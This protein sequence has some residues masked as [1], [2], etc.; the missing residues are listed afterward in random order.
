M[1]IVNAEPRSGD[2]INQRARE[3]HAASAASK[4][5]ITAALRRTSKVLDRALP[6]HLSQPCQAG[7]FLAETEITMRLQALLATTALAFLAT[8]V[9]L[10]QDQ[11]QGGGWGSPQ[12]GQDDFGMGG[13]QG[14]QVLTCYPQ[15]G[16]GPSGAMTMV[17]Y[18]TASGQSGAQSDSDMPFRNEMG[19]PSGS[20][21][22]VRT[23]SVKRPN[24]R[25]SDDKG[26]SN[27]GQQ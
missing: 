18:R 13:G 3:N 25:G 6:S 22:A 2:K 5:V 9:A 7:G 1:T 16:A 10:A 19:S 4:S 14:G 17:C 12:G 8:G 26:S 27:Q 20:D 24:A 23:G 15:G 11:G 21:E